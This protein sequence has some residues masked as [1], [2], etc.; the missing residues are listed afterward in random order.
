MVELVGAFVA[1]DELDCAC[2]GGQAWTDGIV[3]DRAGAHLEKQGVFLAL[4][5]IVFSGCR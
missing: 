4:F 5:R 1:S 3:I 2:V